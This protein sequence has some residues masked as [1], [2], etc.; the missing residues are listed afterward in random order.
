MPI[1]SPP[2]TFRCIACGWKQTTSGPVSDVRIPGINQFTS[3]PRCGGEV[4]VH[5][6]NWLELARGQITRAL[7]RC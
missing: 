1:P 6:A 4:K 7:R 3:C 5:R 2:L